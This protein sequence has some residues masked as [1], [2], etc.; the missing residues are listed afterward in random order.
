M[1]AQPSVRIGQVWADND[2]RAAGRELRILYLWSR[3]Q[4]FREANGQQP[5]DVHYAN[6]VV[7]R[8]DRKGRVAPRTVGRHVDIRLDRFRPTSTGYL[9]IKDVPS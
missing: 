6:C 7:V 9:L 4:T 3:P 8:D 5:A 1:G 2:K